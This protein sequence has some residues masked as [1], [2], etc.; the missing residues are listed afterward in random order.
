MNT[1]KN[2][3]VKLSESFSGMVLEGKNSINESIIEADEEGIVLTNHKYNVDITL[4][5][6]RI[7]FN[8]PKDKL[9]LK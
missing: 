9:I 7:V 6:N 4:N 3:K 8:I 2:K 1:W 5:D